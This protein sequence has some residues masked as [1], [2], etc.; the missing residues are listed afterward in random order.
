MVLVLLPTR[1]DA[2]ASVSPCAGGIRA[3]RP[4]RRRRPKRPHQPGRGAVPH[5]TPGDTLTGAAS[6]PGGATAPPSPSAAPVAW[7]TVGVGARRHH[8]S[9]PAHGAGVR[10]MPICESAAP[11]PKKA[12]RAMPSVTGTSA[13]EG[14]GPV[15]RTDLR[16]TGPHP[17]AVAL[18]ERA[19]RRKNTS[20]ALRYAAASADLATAH[21]RT[22]QRV[23][24]R[25]GAPGARKA[26][27]GRAQASSRYPRMPH[28]Q[29]ARGPRNH[30]RCCGSR[31]R[32]PWP[33]PA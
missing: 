16:A 11:A 1:N 5:R 28:L 13:P 9:A 8:D 31:R 14:C 30:R 15:P 22:G 18:P 19:G 12:P 33:G 27:Q 24:R 26:G 21:T 2:R 10:T 23:Q 6:A 7:R 29:P 25:P 4:S 3:T 20:Q 32:A 17:E